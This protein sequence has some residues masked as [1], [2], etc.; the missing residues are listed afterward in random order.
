MDEEGRYNANDAEQLRAFYEQLWPMM[1]AARDYYYN[2]EAEV[3]GAGTARIWQFVEKHGDIEEP[4]FLRIVPREGRAPLVEIEQPQ[5]D[6]GPVTI[7][8]VEGIEL[9]GGQPEQRGYPLAG[10]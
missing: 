8:T 9:I 1:Q 5:L 7:V 10:S 6:A 4:V 2:R 3:F